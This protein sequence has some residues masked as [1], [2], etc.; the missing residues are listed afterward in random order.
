MLLESGGSGMEA[1]ALH[2]RGTEVREQLLDR[3]CRLETVI[4]RAPD[5]QLAGLLA[6]VDAALDR[7]DH[8]TFGTCDVCHDALEADR[9][10][11]DPLIRTCLGCLT[12]AERGA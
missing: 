12:E 3:R 11:R 1:A 4:A 10:A 2:D 9:L 8:G 7:L 5:A 6:N